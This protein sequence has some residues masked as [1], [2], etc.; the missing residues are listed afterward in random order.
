MR[1]ILLLLGA[2]LAASAG[3]SAEPVRPLESD[4]LV[5]MSIKDGGRLVAEPRLRV[6][7]NNPTNI[8]V[9]DEGGDRYSMRFTLAPHGDRVVALRSSI[10]VARA[11]GGERRV[12]PV[13]L[14]GY[15]APAAIEFGVDSAG[16]QLTRISLRIQP[17]EAGAR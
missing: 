15:K 16:Q 1:T 8:V 2:G 17:V 11:S 7:A 3:A 10:A 5:S 13:L 4:Y 12:E 6:R 14:V 9:S